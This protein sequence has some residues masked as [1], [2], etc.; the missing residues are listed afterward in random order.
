MFETEPCSENLRKRPHYLR[1]GD[2]FRPAFLAADGS[3]HPADSEVRYPTSDAATHAAEQIESCGI[4]EKSTRLSERFFWG[5]VFLFSGL[6][7]SVALLYLSFES[8]DP[9]NITLLG[10]FSLAFFS[11]AFLG[12]TYIVHYYS[13]TRSH[14]R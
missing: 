5:K 8:D 13:Q 4:L 2:L 14:A 12:F 11:A 3:V 6:P 1:D 10:V 7:L 9:K